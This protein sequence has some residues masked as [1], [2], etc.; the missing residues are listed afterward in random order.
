MGGGEEGTSVPHGTDPQSGVVSTPERRMGMLDRVRDSYRPS[1]CVGQSRGRS[2]ITGPTWARYWARMAQYR[3]HVGSANCR[4][5]G[6]SN[7]PSCLF[8]R[9]HGVTTFITSMHKFTPCRPESQQN[10]PDL[11]LDNARRRFKM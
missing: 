11:W 2:L 3:A 5:G 1:P 10:S 6:H 8:C 4:S 7:T 9:D